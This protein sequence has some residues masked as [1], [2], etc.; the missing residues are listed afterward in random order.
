MQVLTLFSSCTF[1]CYTGC[2][3]LKYMKYIHAM[4]D[5]LTPDKAGWSVDVSVRLPVLEDRGI[6]THGF[7]PTVLNPG[8]VKVMDNNLLLVAS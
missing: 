1:K 6:R 5:N 8:R 3:R 7:E 2:F 4:L